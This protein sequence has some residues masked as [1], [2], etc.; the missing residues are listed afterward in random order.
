MREKGE[1]ER[2]RE[3]RGEEEKTTHTHTHAHTHIHTH[4]HTHLILQLQ[5]VGIELCEEGGDVAD[6]CGKHRQTDQEQREDEHY[7]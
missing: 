2:K 1:R 7:L 6:D 4:T 3:K 5:P